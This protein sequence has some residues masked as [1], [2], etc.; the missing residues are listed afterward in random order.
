MPTDAQLPDDIGPDE[1]SLR[2]FER[3]VA[4]RNQ[5][6]EDALESANTRLIDLDNLWV[7]RAAHQSVIVG[8]FMS[9]EQARQHPYN[10]SLTSIVRLTPP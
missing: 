3:E 8:P 2:A 6:V 1:E 9:Y 10:S 5:A 7:I 4:I